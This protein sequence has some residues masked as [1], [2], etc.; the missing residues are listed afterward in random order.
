MKKYVV[1]LIHEY[2]SAGRLI[3]KKLSEKL[4]I[5]YYDK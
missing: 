3:G 4:G 1:A 5:D 2:G